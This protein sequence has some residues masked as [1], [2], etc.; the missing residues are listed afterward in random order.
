VAEL[1]SETITSTLDMVCE[2]PV[3]VAYITASNACI[4]AHVQPP[5]GVDKTTNPAHPA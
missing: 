4:F 1:N 2:I 3:A 5:L